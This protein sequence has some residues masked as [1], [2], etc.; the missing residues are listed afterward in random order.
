MKLYHYFFVALKIIIILLII[1]NKMYETTNS[2]YI[3]GILEDIFAIFVGL[4]VLFFFWPFKKDVNLDKHDKL[5][6]LSAGTLL[7]ITKNYKKLIKDIQ[8]LVKNII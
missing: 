8:V 2:H 7:L 3:E 5:I 6:V 4:M 1:L